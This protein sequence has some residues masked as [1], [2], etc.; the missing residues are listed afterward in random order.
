MH[1][2]WKAFRVVFVIFSAYLLRDVFFR[3]DGF[4]FYATFW[5]FI[6]AVALVM[7]QWSFLALMATL[8]VWGVFIAIEF[9]LSR[10]QLSFGMDQLLLGLLI[11]TLLSGTAMFVIGISVLSIKWIAVLLVISLGITLALRKDA[12]QLHERITPLVWLFGI[13]LIC[14]VP[15]VGY[16]L[17]TADN[18]KTYVVNNDNV[19]PIDHKK[20]N[21]ILVTYDTL[22]AKDMSVYGYQRETTPFIK[23]WAE[24]A[25]S[26]SQLIAESNY[27]TPTTASL[28]TGKHLWTHRLYQPFADTPFKSNIESLPLELKK[29]GYYNMA[30]VANPKASVKTLG[31]TNAFD[32]MP[33]TSEFWSRSFFD[34]NPRN[35]E[36]ILYRYFGGTIKMSNWIIKEDFIVFKLIA[37]IAKDSP[38]IPAPPAVVFNRFLSE[39]NN[40][41]PE[42]YFAWIHIFPPHYTYLPPDPYMGMF[43]DSKKFRTLKAQLPWQE[44]LEYKPEQ[45][46]D[47]D[48]FRARYDEFIRYCDEQFKEFIESFNTRADAGNTYIILSSDHGE[49]FTHGFYRHGAARDLFEPV[50]NIPLIIKA[51]GQQKGLVISD[52]V[53]Q[54]DITSTIL[55]IAGVEVPQ[56]MEGRSL[57]PLMAGERMDLHNIISMVLVK[58]QSRGRELNKGSFSVRKGDY[59]LIHYLEDN[60]SLL[61]NIRSDPDELIDLSGKYPDIT[62]E[63]RISLKRELATANN[64]IKSGQ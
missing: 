57:M 54:I 11:F 19:Q 60:E 3:W 16:K 62:D 26:F 13:W 32:V 9:V 20:P 59:K 40:T 21:I 4:S 18:M 58:N 23:D 36:M 22:T 6:P 5:D 55:E 7:V 39:L 53:A 47:V 41:A 51:P 48:I 52:P 35:I 24:N 15:V 12:G 8:L 50:T 2:F 34:F 27:T 63:L 44:V 56:W 14:S 64:R 17:I 1:S 30:F 33:D 61:F 42:P 43:D 10:F 45:Q 37:L 31:L 46:E 29:A 28:M 25:Y 38:Q 49:S